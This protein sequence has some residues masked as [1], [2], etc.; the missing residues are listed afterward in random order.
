MRTRGIS[1]FSFHF[2][3]KHPMIGATLVGFV[4]GSLALVFP[5]L[6]IRN[7]TLSAVLQAVLVFA[8][9]FGGLILCSWP[10]R[11]Y[12]VVLVSS[13]FANTSGSLVQ[14]T[15]H[16]FDLTF[17]FPGGLFQASG[18]LGFLVEASLGVL[19]TFLLIAPVVWL[20]RRYWPVYQPGHCRKCGYSLFGL[21]S[22]RCPECAEPFT[23]E[24]QTPLPNANDTT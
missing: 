22:N 10:L 8:V 19:T 16:T 1:N 21:S 14:W 20:R 24:D 12:G 9:F 2:L 23:A 18:V 3:N 7:V 5:Q 17:F 11:S 15:R 6:P 13:F 4:C